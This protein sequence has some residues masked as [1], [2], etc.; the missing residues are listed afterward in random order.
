MLWRLSIDCDPPPPL[1]FLY[2][3]GND[4]FWIHEVAANTSQRAFLDGWGASQ[5]VAQISNLWL[6]S[7]PS[8][9]I[10]GPAYTKY[11]NQ[12]GYCA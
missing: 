2:D 12:D 3:N 4:L 5:D 8:H 1:R 7:V 11:G 9:R 6:F 10:W